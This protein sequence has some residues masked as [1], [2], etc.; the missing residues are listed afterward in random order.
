MKEVFKILYNLFPFKRRLFHLLRPFNIPHKIYQH[1]HFKGLITI[2]TDDTHKMKMFHHGYQLENNIFW[3]GIKGWEK[4]TLEIWIKLS[5]QSNVILDIGANTGLFALL[6]KSLNPSAKVFAFEP[7][8]FVFK[9]LEENCALNEYDIQCEQIA[10]SNSDGKATLYIPDSEH[11]Y[12]VAVNKNLNNPDVKY[13]E[14]QVETTRLATYIENN[15]IDHIDL[16]KIDVETHEPEVLEGLC[17]YI[18]RFKPTL[19]IEILNDDIGKRVQDLISG[20]N[21]LY[22]DIDDSNE[23]T[24]TKVDN[25]K[26]SSQWNYLVCQPEVASNLNLI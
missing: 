1:L 24:P 21:Y 15:K 7:V 3:Q 11:V 17:P 20:L 23:I 10:I 2:K 13:N 16:I 5:K 14:V 9:K 25:I 18:E 22:F 6:S 8:D 19:L 26:K 12:S 4:L